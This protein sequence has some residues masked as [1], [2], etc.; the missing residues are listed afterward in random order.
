MKSKSPN[1]VLLC[2]T[3]EMPD[4]STVHNACAFMD[5]ILLDNGLQD[6]F[7]VKSS[8]DLGGCD[9]PIGLAIQ[10]VGRAS[11][12]FHSVS[13]EQ[14]SA[15]IVALCRSYLQSEA[16]WIEDARP[17]GRLRFCLRARVPAAPV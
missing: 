5:K 10:G 8:P 13:L 2:E 1:R 3:C 12:V 17:L 4:G 11:Y 14:D 15:D 7:D 6:M 16:G 9:L